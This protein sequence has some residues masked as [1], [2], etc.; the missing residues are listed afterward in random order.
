[1][2]LMTVQEMKKKLAA[3]ESA[4]A[5]SL[6]KWCRIAGTNAKSTF[7]MTVIFDIYGKQ[8][9]C[10]L[11]EKHGSH[12]EYCE[13]LSCKE[14]SPWYKIAEAAKAG[15]IEAFYKA[16]DAMVQVLSMLAQREFETWM[17]GR[18]ISWNCNNPVKFHHW[19]SNAHFMDT[20][21]AIW[22][23]FGHGFPVSLTDSWSVDTLGPAQ[24]EFQAW[25]GD[26]LIKWTNN[27]AKIR[28]YKWLA[29][30]Q[31]EDH[32]GSQWTAFGHGFPEHDSKSNWE[33]AKTPEQE[34]WEK[35]FGE[36]KIR[37]IK[38]NIVIKFQKWLD[39]NTFLDSLDGE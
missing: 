15:D 17:A 38:A 24:R 29:D 11:C 10:A 13:L 30:N 31:F 8:S 2:N 4:V 34:E 1:M 16:T 25:A 23:A 20:N 14:G 27:P 6:D 12:C 7:E 22:Q 39:N 26:R 3:G 35:E 18:R 32:T 21:D 36:R 19:I 37:N 5:V 33:Y 28:F 9:T